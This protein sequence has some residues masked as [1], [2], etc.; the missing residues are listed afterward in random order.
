MRRLILLTVVCVALTVAACDSDSPVQP[1]EL[2]GTPFSR[3]DAGS[4]IAVSAVSPSEID[5]S[6]A[7]TPSASGYQIFRSDN[8]ATGSY[9]LIASTAATVTS[10][11]NTGL[12]G[13]T[14]YCYEIRSFKTSGR[15]TT[16]SAYSNAACATTLAPPVNA[17]SDVDVVPI[18]STT[19]VY[20]YVSNLRVS[21]KDNSANEDE[22]HLE[23]ASA[24]AGPW[25]QAI[26]T[27]ANITLQ[28]QYGTREQQVCFRVIA[29]SAA[30][31]SM[32]SSVDCT[33]PPA[34]PTNLVAKAADGQSITL[35]WTDNS[36]IEDGYKISRLEPGGTWTDIATLAPNAVSYR[37]PGVAADITYTYRVQ[38]LKDGGFSD[39]SNE[40][41]V[42]I[43]TSPPT[44]PSGATASYW[45]D[46]EYGWLYFYLTWTD[47]SSNEEGFR[48]EFSADSVSGWRTYTTVAANQTG[49]FGQ[50][51]LWASLAPFAE[52]YRV[53][54]FNSAGE[55]ASNATCTEWYNPPTNL[56]ATAVD[57][58]SIDLTWTD[59][60][61][62]ENGYVVF[63]STSV[64]GQYDVIAETPANAT[65]YR[66]TGLATGQEYW[67]FV[68]SDFGGYSFYDIFNYS[69]RVSAT[70]LSPTVSATQSVGSSRTVVASL[71]TPL[72]VKG[73]PT[74]DDLRARYK[75]EQTSVPFGGAGGVTPTR[76]KRPAI[77]RTPPVR[78][79]KGGY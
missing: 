14:Q 67:Y 39:Y 47:A 51:D 26:T 20:P 32:P 57:A 1:R 79:R 44:A 2:G 41:I 18:P 46:N 38:A 55:S 3:G 73:R 16:Y 33:T 69:D 30:G 61:Q 59:N 37:D 65:S 8:G 70:T 6:W 64:D 66:D 13:S 5:L 29:F 50:Y 74:L 31:A 23:R 34:S 17:P 60:G 53:V 24:P 11:A 56:T 49:F 48:I 12:I 27:S 9:S 15:N 71:L 42:S 75:L 45:S 62:F 78:G 68:A 76:V 35:T 72:H 40:A 77:R 7:N 43:A 36:A 22:F 21:W 52:C 10:Y 19:I 63:R 28:Y 25:T 4:S 58:Q 54:A